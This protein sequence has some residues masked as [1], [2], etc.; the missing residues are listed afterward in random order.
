MRTIIKLITLALIWNFALSSN[1]QD[2]TRFNDTVEELDKMQYN[3]SSDKKLVLFTG[4]STIRGWKDVQS[5]F[6]RFNVINNGF[7]GSHYS[8][9]L[10]FYEKLILKHSPDILFIYEGDND[11]ATGK[12]ISEI[13]KTAKI[14]INRAVTDLP[15]TQ[16]IIISAKPSIAREQLKNQYLKLNRK[17]EKLC[18]KYPNLAFAD[19]W[20]AMTNDSGEVYK[21]IFLEDGLHMNK[22]GYQIWVE[23]LSYYL[24]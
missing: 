14:L 11:I 6:P 15:E 20:S 16:I 10:F 1:A 3:F 7:G 21:D 23:E 17:L 9:L 22:K 13:V 19:L 4:S 2:P 18:K 8:D 24:K 12:K 5:C